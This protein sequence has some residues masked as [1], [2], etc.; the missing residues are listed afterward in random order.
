MPVV[1][2]MP[3]Y[4]ADENRLSALNGHQGL[5]IVGYLSLIQYACMTGM[6]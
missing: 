1:G 6:A 3:S 2:Q 4:C 5:L